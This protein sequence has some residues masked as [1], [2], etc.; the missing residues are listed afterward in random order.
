MGGGVDQAAELGRGARAARGLG[1]LAAL[2]LG[3]LAAL[4]LGAC[5]SGYQPQPQPPPAEPPPDAGVTLTQSEHAD[6]DGA[7]IVAVEQA[8][9]A[10]NQPIHACWA[11]AAADDFRLEGRVVLSVRVGAGGKPEQIAVVENTTEDD[12]LSSCL[13]ELWGRY[14]FP[15]EAIAA[16]QT[17]QLPMEFGAPNAQYV[18]SAA[19]VAPEQIARTGGEDDPDATSTA[20]RHLLTP[21]NTG[22]GAFSLAELTLRSQ[23]APHALQASRL[24]YVVSGAGRVLGSRSR[25]LAPGD[26]VYVPAGAPAGL[27]PTGKVPLVVL[28]I[29]APPAAGPKIVGRPPGTRVARLRGAAPVVRATRAQKAHVIG[30]GSGRAAILVDAAVT[31]PNVPSLVALT[32][33]AGS[34]VPA[35]RHPEA[36]EVLY[37]FEGKGV[38]TVAGQEIPVGAGDAIQIPSGIEHAFRADPEGGAVKALQSYAPAGPEQRF[39]G[40]GAAR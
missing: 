20:V 35:H 7:A 18:V 1:A 30:G 17:V 29:L 14:T 19:H 22:N 25:K 37:L 24:Y 26:A 16:G 21:R 6:E 38:M 15:P 32:L 5:S 33:E 4:G 11:Q 13:T 9:N 36:T 23:I 27:E 34:Q 10:L 39:K 3:A 12:V 28:R 8:V 2:G 40:A 31:G